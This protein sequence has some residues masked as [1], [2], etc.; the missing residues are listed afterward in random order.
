MLGLNFPVRLD[1]FE[2]Q[3]FWV[4]EK[5]GTLTTMDKFGRGVNRT[6]Q[7]GLVRPH[8]VRLLHPSKHDI[9]STNAA[10][11]ADRD[12]T[13]PY[14]ISREHNTVQYQQFSKEMAGYQKSQLDHQ[15]DHTI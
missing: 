5:M 13:M 10:A 1:V 14:F 11:A 9:A 7:T 4:S 12:D 3:L 8:A 6:L 15:A 2:S